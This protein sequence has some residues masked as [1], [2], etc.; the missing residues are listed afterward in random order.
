MGQE[1]KKGKSSTC[2]LTPPSHVTCLKRPNVFPVPC[3]LNFFRFSEHI[4]FHKAFH[5]HKNDISI[6][7]YKWQICRKRGVKK[8]ARDSLEAVLYTPKERERARSPLL[9]RTS[10]THTQA[11]LEAKVNRSTSPSLPACLPGRGRCGAS[12]R[13]R[14]WSSLGKVHPRSGRPPEKAQGAGFWGSP[15]VSLFRFEGRKEKR[16]ASSREEPSLRVQTVTN[17]GP[18]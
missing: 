14:G 3:G 6:F 17:Q 12:W 10:V 5:K 9:A 13:R 18:N 4:A 1:R 11:P 2:G 16:K 8:G 7:P 15:T